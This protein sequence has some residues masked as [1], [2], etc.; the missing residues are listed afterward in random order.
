ML[1]VR[2]QLRAAA[3]SR[4]N[5]LGAGGAG[6][7]KDDGEVVLHPGTDDA[8]RGLD[9]VD[10]VDAAYGVEGG[11]GVE[12]GGEEADE[13]LALRLLPLL[14]LLQLSEG[15]E[16]GVHGAV[17]HPKLVGVDVGDLPHVPVGQVDPHHVLEHVERS[18]FL[19]LLH[20]SSTL[21]PPSP[22]SSF[23]PSPS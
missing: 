16:D 23:S 7:V 10:E 18:L 11:G 2:S 17:D 3:E 19:H 1:A 13:A 9:P 21:L 12:L 14:P 5:I 4:R 8:E 22:S 15:V 6:R 20:S